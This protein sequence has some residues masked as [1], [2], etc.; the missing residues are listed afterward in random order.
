M[1]LE[2]WRD[3]EA[4]CSSTDLDDE[5]AS[6]RGR[7]DVSIVESKL[8]RKIKMRRMAK[9]EDGTDIG[10]EEYYDYNFPDDEKKIV[11]LKILENALKWKQAMA[12]GVTA[13]SSSSDGADESFAGKKRNADEIEIDEDE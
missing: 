2:A 12:G 4:A 6:L 5:E 11:G 8:P 3:C 9:A 7:G 1:I 10:W 13:A